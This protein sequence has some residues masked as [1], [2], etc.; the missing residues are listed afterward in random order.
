MEPSCPRV[1]SSTF[2]VAA[3]LFLL[4]CFFAR[5]KRRN[6]QPDGSTLGKEEKN[7]L[8]E[9]IMK[10][11]VE[12]NDFLLT[13]QLVIPLTATKLSFLFQSAACLLINL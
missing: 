3:G 1:N 7:Q 5:A 12:T 10:K 9:E 4:N 13:K 6:G 2:L 8:V 11:N